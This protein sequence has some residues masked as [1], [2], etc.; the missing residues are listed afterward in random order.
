MVSYRADAQGLPA[1]MSMIVSSHIFFPSASWSAIESI[2]HALFARRGC[3]RAWRAT[4]VLRRFLRHA[5]NCKLLQAIPAVG[6]IDAQLKAFVLDQY[7]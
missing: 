3:M 5:R 2:L 6:L 7:V 1:V 4:A